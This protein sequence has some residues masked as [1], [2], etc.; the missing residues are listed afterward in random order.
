MK[1]L[2][3]DDEDDI[4][5]TICMSLERVGKLQV[6]DA[7]SGPAG[8]SAARR[9]KPDAILLDVMMPGMEGPAVLTALRDDPGTAKIP[10]IFLTAGLAPGELMR[11]KRLGA[12]GVIAK[13]F[14]PMTLS[15]QIL[16]LLA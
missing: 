4:R 9:E 2:I 10:V 12:A 11:L 3:I 1:I 6:C 13:P 16:E 8:V 15:K 14:D 7:D 5:R